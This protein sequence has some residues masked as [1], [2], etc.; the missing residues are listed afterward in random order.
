MEESPPALKPALVLWHLR[1][2]WG[3][4]FQAQ[5]NHAREA[6]LTGTE[7]A[8]FTGLSRQ[9]VARRFERERGVLIL[10]RPESMHKRSYRSIRISDAVCEAPSVG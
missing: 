3:M 7:V 1:R 8:A 6:A 5:R 9:T 2:D 4:A 10:A